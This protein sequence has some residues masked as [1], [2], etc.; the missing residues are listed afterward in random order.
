MRDE[1]KKQARSNKQT[2][3]S[4]AAH[5]RQSLVHVN[6]NVHVYCVYTCTHAHSP[7]LGGGGASAAISLD[8]FFLSLRQYY[9]GLRQEGAGLATPSGCAISPQEVE[10]LASVL[11]LIQSIARLVRPHP[12]HVT[13]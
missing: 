7:L 12:H 9:L 6:V 10:G 5:P 11:K 3:Q 13:Y 2:R 4:N 1:R 8:H